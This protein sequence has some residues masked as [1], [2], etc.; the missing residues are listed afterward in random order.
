MIKDPFTHQIIGL[1]METHRALGPGLVEEFYHQDLVARLNKSGIEHLSKPRRDL[2][3]RGFVA[4][5]FE[6][7]LVFER[8]LIP[9]LKALRGEFAP[10]HFTQL[11]SYSK[12]WRIC[13]G[14]LIDFGKPSLYPKRVIYTSK[15][16]VFPDVRI[17]NFVTDPELARGLVR[18]A[19]QCLADIA[20]G[21][22]ETTWT[23]LLSAALRAEQ[24]PFVVNPA[25]S[26][27]EVG[28]T[29]LRCFVINNQAAITV[30]ALGHEVTAIDRACLQ[31]YLRLLGLPWG[32][33]F[34]FG[35]SKADLKFV[36]APTLKLPKS[37]ISPADSENPQVETLQKN[38]LRDIP[39]STS[40]EN[41][42]PF[43]PVQHRAHRIASA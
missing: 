25:V 36:S 11:L 2:M 1:A 16:G 14:L 12:F 33:S 15:T 22:R 27:P 17:P 35:K 4:D 7:D 38:N 21:Y 9:E 29:S 39:S 40:H 20:F 26:V 28:T 30:T 32:I 6:A 8:R 10:E 5:T 18:I 24:L 42:P 23:G 3:Y 34:H 43:S 37:S 41:P 19:D 31:T 13:T